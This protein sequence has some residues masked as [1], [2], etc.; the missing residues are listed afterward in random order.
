[1]NEDDALFCSR[2]LRHAALG[3]L[4][5]GP[6]AAGAIWLLLERTALLDSVSLGADRST[7]TVIGLIAALLV[8]IW[9]GA[10][11]SCMFVRKTTTEDRCYGG[12]LGCLINLLGGALGWLLGTR[13]F[14]SD[15]HP[16]LLFLIGAVA[17]SAVA[18]GFTLCCPRARQ[19]CR[20]DAEHQDD[21]A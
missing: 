19:L 6:V 15:L 2:M 10:M 5:G 21:S 11:V 12:T 8:G 20:T 7:L 13:L 4:V 3:A 16:V 18:F 17:L 1:M 9:L 14:D